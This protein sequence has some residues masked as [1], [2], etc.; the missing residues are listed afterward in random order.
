MPPISFPEQS[1]PICTHARGARDRGMLLYDFNKKHV[2]LLKSFM[3]E[4]GIRELRKSKRCLH[5]GTKKNKRARVRGA[6]EIKMRL[7]CLSD[8][9]NH[10]L[11]FRNCLFM[12]QFWKVSAECNLWCSFGKEKNKT[13][14]NGHSTCP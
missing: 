1:K 13:E 14:C 8:V 9:R 12:V 5:W 3:S 4:V 10:A 6:D 11:L 2:F 7:G